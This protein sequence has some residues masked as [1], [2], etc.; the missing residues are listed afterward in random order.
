[1]RIAIC[2]IMMVLLLQCCTNENM[3]LKGEIESLRK[4]SIMDLNT[5][6]ESWHIQ[7]SEYIANKYISARKENKPRLFPGTNNKAIILLHGFIGSPFEISSAA[8]NLNKAGYTV[9]APLIYG[10]GGDT[11]L[12]NTAS[13]EDWKSTLRD[14]ISYLAPC[15]NEFTLIG[16]SLGGTIL[17]DF[18]LSEIPRTEDITINSVV[19][20]APYYKSNF[21]GSR[22]INTV[23]SVLMKS[24]SLKTLYKV[25]HHSDLPTPLNNPQ[26]YNN[27]IPLN[28]ISELFKFDDHLENLS[29]SSRSK[30][31]TLLITSEY[32]KTI[33]RKEVE[34]FVSDNFTD[35]EI[36]CYKKEKK[37]RHQILV[38]EANRYLESTNSSILK[39]VNSH[40]H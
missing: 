27:E 26:Y 36:I 31:P 9:F 4:T 11:Q 38:P 32:D 18:I 10:F 25:S 1:M 3:R 19:L 5:C 23:L 12:A 17:I 7:L 22:I 20:I 39:F 33:E 29:L 15:Y 14:S 21:L 35:I 40:T 6:S 24:I 30:I 8:E 2:W 16:F 37:I 13:I 34:K 28:A